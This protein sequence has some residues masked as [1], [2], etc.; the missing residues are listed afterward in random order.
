MSHQKVAGIMLSVML[1]LLIASITLG[2][3][4][5][6]YKTLLLRQAIDVAFFSYIMFGAYT[7]YFCY[8][9]FREDT[10][11]AIRW[12]GN[13]LYHATWGVA[14]GIAIGGILFGG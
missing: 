1:M 11:R 8:K 14:F 12:V 2:F 13:L 4:S 3:F 5:F 6:T 7:L 10:V 9:H